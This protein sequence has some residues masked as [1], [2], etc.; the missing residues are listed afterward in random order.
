MKNFENEH[1]I[2]QNVLIFIKS[3]SVNFERPGYGPFMGTL[4]RVR[5]DQDA[6]LNITIKIV[7]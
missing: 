1:P 2:R 6:N 4:S 3:R 5:W 7:I